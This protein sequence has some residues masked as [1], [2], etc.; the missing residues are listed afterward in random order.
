MGK[1]TP[2]GKD[3]AAAADTGS[4]TAPGSGAWVR[5]PAGRA[6]IALSGNFTGSLRLEVSFDGGTTAIPCTSLG[7]TVDFTAPM[8]EEIEEIEDGV[9]YRWTATALSAGQADWR[10]SR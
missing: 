8:S 10:I 5:V 4:L 1:L 7:A 6:N 2:L 9:L 3:L